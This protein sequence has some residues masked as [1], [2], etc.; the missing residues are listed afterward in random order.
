VSSF[1]KCGEHVAAVVVGLVA[2]PLGEEASAFEQNGSVLT[3]LDLSPT[4]E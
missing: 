1:V 3:A 4:D 2:I